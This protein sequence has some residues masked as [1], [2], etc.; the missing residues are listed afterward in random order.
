VLLPVADIPVAYQS[1]RI[2]RSALFAI[3]H[4]GISPTS[5]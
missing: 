1:S 5:T 3:M 4:V 2:V